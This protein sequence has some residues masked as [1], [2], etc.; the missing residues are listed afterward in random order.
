MSKPYFTVRTVWGFCFCACTVAMSSTLYYVE[1]AGIISNR[2]VVVI[3]R[4]TSKYHQTLGDKMFGDPGRLTERVNTFYYCESAQELSIDAL[5]VFGKPDSLLMVKGNESAS[6]SFTRQKDAISYRLSGEKKTGFIEV[7]KGRSVAITPPEGLSHTACGS[8]DGSLLWQD[9]SSLWSYDLLKKEFVSIGKTP[10]S[11]KDNAWCNSMH[12]FFMNSFYAKGTIFQW[13]DGE[14]CIRKY[15]TVTGEAA[16]VIAVKESVVYSVRQAGDQVYCVFTLL[17]S[18]RVSQK[19]SG[20][21][22]W[23]RL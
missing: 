18:H 10:L 11:G 15:V 19:H 9:G 22:D 23:F 2:L 8:A 12:P 4:S 17:A 13:R 1:D 5:P 3:E 7:S 21:H 16:G 14:E 20:F 6:L